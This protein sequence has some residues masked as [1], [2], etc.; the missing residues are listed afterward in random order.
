M[1]SIMLLIS[2]YLVEDQY[3]CTCILCSVNYL[4]KSQTRFVQHYIFLQTALKLVFMQL[5]I[6]ID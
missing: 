3:F 6:A 5:H 1:N 2:S 4:I